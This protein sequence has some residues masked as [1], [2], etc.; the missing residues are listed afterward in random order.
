MEDDLQEMEIMSEDEE[1][2]GNEPNL[3]NLCGT[4]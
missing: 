1:C 4:R 3:G 2:I